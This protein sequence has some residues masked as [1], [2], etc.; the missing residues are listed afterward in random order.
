MQLFIRLI[1]I[2]LNIR[3]R[4]SGCETVRSFAARR[5]GYSV[6]TSGCIM[7]LRIRAAM[8]CPC[9]CSMSCLGS[10]WWWPGRR[11]RVLRNGRL[12]SKTRAKSCT[13]R[14]DSP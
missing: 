10:K 13:A 9:G 11:G 14:N 2:S 4:V 1:G 5:H 8:W 7:T 12:R 6:L 3:H